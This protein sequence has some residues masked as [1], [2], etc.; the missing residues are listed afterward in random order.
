MYGLGQAMSQRDGAP[1]PMGGGMPG[2]MG[3]AM[4]GGM[5]MP[6]QGANSLLGAIKNNGTAQHQ[7]LLQMLAQQAQQK[8]PQQQSGVGL[9]DIAKLAAMFA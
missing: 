4:M 5:P 9:G 3:G 2:M 1:Q 8:Q 6:G 7:Q